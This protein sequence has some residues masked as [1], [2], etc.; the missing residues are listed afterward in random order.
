MIMCIKEKETSSKP[1]TGIN[2]C[3]THVGKYPSVPI[4]KC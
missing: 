4:P 2:A 3:D 1:N